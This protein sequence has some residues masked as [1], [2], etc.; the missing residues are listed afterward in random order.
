MIDEIVAILERAKADIQAR[1]AEEGINASGRSSASLRV[2]AY[3]GGVRLMYGNPD[4]APF[5]TLEVGR[6][7]GPVPRGFT[8]ILVQWSR[9]KGIAFDTERERRSFA[10]LLGRRIEREGTLRHHSPV[11]VYTTIVTDTA[12]AIKADLKV[13]VTELIH[14]ELKKTK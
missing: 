14:E 4:T 3:D 7:G 12:E 10:Y 9:D 8:D 2:E 5:E 6:P 11:D 1:L 13:M